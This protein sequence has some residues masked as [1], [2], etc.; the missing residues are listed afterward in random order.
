MYTANNSKFLVLFGLRN[1]VY[2]K[3]VTVE[4]SGRT[5]IAAAGHAENSENAN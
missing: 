3:T 5:G 1:E 4:W 2:A